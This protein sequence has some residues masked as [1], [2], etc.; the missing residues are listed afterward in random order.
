M[1]SLNSQTH[2][3]DVT[4]PIALKTW[5]QRYVASVS[6]RCASF[7]AA[8]DLY[9]ICWQLVPEVVFTCKDAMPNAAEFP[10]AL[11]GPAVKPGNLGESLKASGSYAC[12]VPRY[13]MSEDRPKLCHTAY[14]D[15][16]ASHYCETVFDH[17]TKYKT[18]M[19]INQYC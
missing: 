2:P 6:C 10:S 9:A 18:Q 8:I 17:T 13:C 12:S 15:K 11:F 14:L 7:L 1:H 16:A 3:R 4:C 5:M 19:H